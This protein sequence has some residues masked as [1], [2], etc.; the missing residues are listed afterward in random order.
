MA[1]GLKVYSVAHRPEIDKTHNGE[2]II[3]GDAAQP[4]MPTHAQGGSIAIED[5]AALEV[6]RANMESDEDIRKRLRLWEQ[7][8]LPRCATAQIVSNAMFD[9]SDLNKTELM[10]RYYQGPLSSM[11]AESWSEP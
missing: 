5:V 6:L 11:G 7:L 10:R 2:T 9:S 8:R 1:E 3:I 4:M